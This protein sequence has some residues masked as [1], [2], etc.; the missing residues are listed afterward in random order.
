[1]PLFPAVSPVLVRSEDDI[2][3]CLRETE[4]RLPA[5][6]L[7]EYIAYLERIEDGGVKL[8]SFGRW[9]LHQYCL[10]GGFLQATFQYDGK[11]VFTFGAEIVPWES[12]D[13]PLLPDSLIEEGPGALTLVYRELRHRDHRLNIEVVLP[14][15]LSKT[16][17]N[18]L[19]HEILPFARNFFFYQPGLGD[20][21]HI[22]HLDVLDQSALEILTEHVKHGRHV[23]V[24]HFKF[25]DLHIYLEMSGEHRTR[26]LMSA[27]IEYILSNLKYAD[28]LVQISPLSYIVL[29]PGAN[30]EQILERFKN[31]YFQVRSLVLEYE[32]HLTTVRKLPIRLPEIWRELK[33]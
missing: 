9:Y 16:G 12:A 30:E 26:D 25:Q 18:L 7:N 8:G 24:S 22:D 3:E 28:M 33:L 4:L 14:A 1:M 21:R 29:S 32:I 6:L 27:I 19:D 20:P 17:Q 31:I 23:T 2:R 13:V 15:K 5:P 11:A 10:N